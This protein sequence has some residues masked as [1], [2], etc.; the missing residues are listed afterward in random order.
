VVPAHTPTPAQVQTNRQILVSHLRLYTG[1]VLATILVTGCR[2]NEPMQELSTTQV[3]LID[4]ERQ[5]QLGRV[6]TLT[7]LQGADVG[8]IMSLPRE[9]NY[10]GR[11]T[12]IEVTVQDDSVSRRHARISLRDGHYE[13]ED[14]GSTNGTYVAGAMVS[15]RVRLIDGVR[16]QLGNTIMRFG[17]QDEVER[18]ASKRIYEMSVRDGLTGV[19]NRRYFDDRLSS[20]FAYALRHRTPLCVILGDIDHFKKINDTHGHPVGDLVLRR[21]AAELQ[22]S[23]RTED[24]VARFGGEEFVVMARGI[25]I[26]GGRAFAERMRAVVQRAVIMAESTRVPTTMSLGVAHTHNA[27][28][29]MVAELLVEAADV[30]LY[31]AK[32]GGRNRVEVANPGRYGAPANTPVAPTPEK[33]KRRA[34]DKPTAPADMSAWQNQAKR[35]D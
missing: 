28:G 20:E 35:K 5:S 14:L 33:V 10:L 15:G 6:G 24:L 11:D 22:A 4:P 17:M 31:A 34:W 27:P 18:A 25:D 1:T 13:V 29:I 32:R 26:E 8:A 23:V 12:Q 30:A 7:V 3:T 19:Y 16:V 2:L 9:V 21:V